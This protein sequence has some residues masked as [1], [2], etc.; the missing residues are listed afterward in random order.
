MGPLGEGIAEG[1]DRSEGEM[2]HCQQ[3]KNL[4]TDYTDFHRLKT[5]FEVKNLCNLGNLWT[6][7]FLWG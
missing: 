3:L 6:F 1:E 7:L 5:R 4:S 2:P